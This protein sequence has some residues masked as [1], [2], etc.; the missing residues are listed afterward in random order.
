MF[1]DRKMLKFN[2]IQRLLEDF[3]YKPGVEVEVTSGMQPEDEWTK[4]VAGHEI[5]MLRVVMRTLDSR[6]EYPHGAERFTTRAM[7]GFVPAEGLV[8]E[9]PSGTR[10][11][12]NPIKIQRVTSVPEYVLEDE[13]HFLRWLRDFIF[14]SLEGHE[15]DEWFKMKGV[16]VFDAH[17]ELKRRQQV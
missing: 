5:I 12:L 6:L 13:H 7:H 16:P 8:I 15:V 10:F 9:T 11:T 1:G 2:D 17:P 14:H 3:T 4:Y